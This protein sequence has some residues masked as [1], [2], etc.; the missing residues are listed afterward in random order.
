MSQP[1]NSVELHSVPQPEDARG[2]G[3]DIGTGSELCDRCRQ[4]DIQTFSRS[5]DRTHGYLLSD[6][7][8]ATD[9]QRCPFCSLL[10]ESVRDVERPRDATENEFNPWRLPIEQDPGMYIHMKLC[11]DYKDPETRYPDLRLKAN[12]LLVTLA[13]RF[14]DVRNAS[15]HEICLA[16]EPDSP[17]A[18]SQDVTG[19]YLG[20]D[21][22]SDAHFEMVESWIETCENHHRKCNQT[23]SGRDIDTELPARCI[24]ISIT[25]ADPHVRLISTRTEGGPM[26][27]KYITLTH[28]WNEETNRCKTTTTNHDERNQRI[29]LAGLPKLFRDAFD[30][31]TRLRVYYV[32]IDSLCIIQEGDDLADWKKEAPKMAQ[33]Y[34]FSQLTIAGTMDD[35]TSGLIHPYP[36]EYFP[37][38]SNLV[39]LPYRDRSGAQDGHVFV[40]KRRVP[41]VQ[42]YWAAIRDSH[43]FRRGWILQEWLLSKRILWYT[44][45]GLFFECATDGP[46][47]E[48]KERIL[49]ENARPNL[50]PHLHLKGSFH[51][52]NAFILDSWYRV[53]EQYSSCNLTKP[54]QDRILAVA[55]LAKE[56]GQILT[57]RMRKAVMGGVN[58]EMYMA[59]LWLRDLHHGL[60]WEE[61][62]SAPPWKRSV[63]Q[64]PS[65][66]WA[67][68][69]TPVRWAQ[70]DK[71]AKQELRV[72]GF[73]QTSQD[74]H[75]HEPEYVVEGGWPVQ[76]L[77]NNSSGMRRTTFDPTNMFTCLH[78]RSKLHTVHVRGYL[79]KES[80]LKKA[81]A[82]TAYGTIPGA[83]KWRALCSPS[84]PEVIAGWA[85]PERLSMGDNATICADAGIAVHALYISTRFRRSG[86]LFKHKDT[87]LDVLLVE[88]IDVENQVFRR[89]GIGR[90]FDPDLIGEFETNAK[91]NIQLV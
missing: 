69:M 37:W 77:S 52:D 17:A 47:T 9:R 86:L 78:I 89:V 88:E 67:S 11:E 73:C 15:E 49:V 84:R 63:T 28:R 40:Y 70:K 54:D 27:D 71:E 5:N 10:L 1:V 61:D 76:R 58:H 68:L 21:P 34:Q 8:D 64:A 18:K 30:I 83:G 13:D 32:W 80:D 82:A 65:W 36:E 81:A 19:Q 39:L 66:S 23:V 41:V 45:H 57:Q 53:I 59:G 74:S 72:L 22:R 90:I 91:R 48:Y 12:R 3:D 24:K 55:G 87:V 2:D 14:S 29:D 35:M 51:Y 62:Y 4:F 26:R 25:D 46:R 43:L 33:Y 7:R 44:S 6:V 16:A 79:E 85:S 50:Q 42:D 31:A 38:E 60:L 20:R 75:D 56:V